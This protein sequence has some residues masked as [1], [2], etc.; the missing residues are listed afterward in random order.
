VCPDLAAIG[1]QRPLRLDLITRTLRASV[2]LLGNALTAPLTQA[3]YLV[4][5]LFE[6]IRVEAR[7]QNVRRE[8]TFARLT[9]IL[10]PP[11]SA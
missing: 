3:T 10:R 11:S 7:P 1:L 2:R 8:D 6:E 4:Q 5:I 9:E